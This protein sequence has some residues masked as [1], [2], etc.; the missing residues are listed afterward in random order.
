M[1]SPMASDTMRPDVE[2]AWTK[3]TNKSGKKRDIRKLGEYL[4]DDEKVLTMGGGSTGGHSGL[5]VAT[6]RRV[7]F[8]AEGV[9]NH[10]FEDF[11]YDRVTS[12]RTNRGMMLAKIVIH[13]AGTPRVIENMNKGEAEA[14]SAVVRERIEAHT[15]T[16]TNP[17]QDGPATPPPPPAASLATQLRELAELR[18]SGVLTQDEFE[19]QKARMLQG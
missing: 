11:P 19:V 2:A 1:M 12:I 9:M 18:D 6:T 15:R 16:A 8:V 3:I 4:G 13:S 5:L 10:S 7:M 17:V 14:L